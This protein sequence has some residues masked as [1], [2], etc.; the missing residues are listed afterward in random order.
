MSEQTAVDFVL[1]LGKKEVTYNYVGSINAPTGYIDGTTATIVVTAADGEKR[2]FTTNSFPFNINESGFKA[3]NGT[4]SIS[5]IE[6][7]RIPK[8]DGDGNTIEDA[9]DEVEVPK[10]FGSQPVNFTQAQ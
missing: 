3:A 9:Y 5:G 8:T 2:T 1:S 6:I 7:N 4:V 10:D